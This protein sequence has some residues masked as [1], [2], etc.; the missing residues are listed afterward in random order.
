MI[1]KEEY[2]K[3]YNQFL[4]NCFIKLVEETIDEN[5]EKDIL[6]DSIFIDSNTYDE[7]SARKMLL[8]LTNKYCENGWDNLF[9]ELEKREIY[10][11]SFSYHYRIKYI[12]S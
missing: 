2:N 6:K 5:I 9:F 7:E 11:P 3:K 1:S 12:L 10:M 8:V 4:N